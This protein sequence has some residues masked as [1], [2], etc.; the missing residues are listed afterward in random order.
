MESN[1]NLQVIE[2]CFDTEWHDLQPI[3]RTSLIGQ[4]DGWLLLDDKQNS[5][6]IIT[7]KD[8]FRKNPAQLKLLDQLNQVPFFDFF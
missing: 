8:I 1:A 7:D 6:R 3:Q 5:S 2:C 4:D